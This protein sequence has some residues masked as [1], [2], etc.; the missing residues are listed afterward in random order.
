LLKECRT[1]GYFRAE[2]CPVC[3]EEG[4]FLMNDEEIDSLGRTMAGILRHFPE[5][6]NLTMD[7]HG[8]VNL[9][10]FVN[11]IRNKQRRFRWLKQHHIFAMV[12]TDPKKRYQ[13]REGNIRA[14][15]AHSIELKLDL[16]TR[17]IPDVLY[18][19]T[20]PE[21]APLLMETGL[22]PADRKMV[23][24]SKTY[25]AAMIAGKV[26]V[27]EPKILQIDAKK[28]LSDGVKIQKAGTTVYLAEEVPPQYL[29]FAEIPPVDV[30]LETD[31][32]GRPIV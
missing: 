17:D 16:P 26:R 20:T 9:D 19:P 6:Y 32:E 31:P 8:W 21:E 4:R 10:D 22:R 11:N 15:Y 18:Y 5:R 2:E 1:H 29:A 27:T 23:H 28:A 7:E 14:T 30:Q 25:E 13:V 24:L 3:G 12:D